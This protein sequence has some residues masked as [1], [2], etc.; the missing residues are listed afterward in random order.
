M[1]KAGDYQVIFYARLKPGVKF[2][3]GKTGFSL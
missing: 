2:E 1:A 3:A